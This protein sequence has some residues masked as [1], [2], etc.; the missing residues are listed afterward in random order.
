LIYDWNKGGLIDLKGVVHVELN[1]ETLRDGLQ[2]PSVTDPPIEKK[3]RILHLM[4]QLGIHSANIGLPGAGP[5]AYQDTLALAT[6]IA[7]QKMKIKPNC[8]ARTVRSD[9]TPIIEISQKTGLPIEVATFIGSSPIRQFVEGWDVDM[10]QKLTE[11]AVRYVV[12]N[13]LPSMYVTEDTTRSHPDTIERLYKTAIECGSRRVVIADT[14]GHAIRTGTTNVV[15]FVKDVVESSGEDVKID[16]HGHSDRGF[17]LSCALA[18]IR[19]GVDRVHATALGIG[20][21]SGNTQMDLLLVNLKMMGILN[22][23][24][25]ALH[26]YCTTVAEATEVPVPFNYPIVGNDA[27]RTATGVHAS[28]II[29]AMKIGDNGIADAV[30]SG[31]PAHLVGRQQQIEIGP[32]SGESNV[33]FWLEHHGYEP[34]KELIKKIYE[35]AKHSNKILKD[36]EIRDL[37]FKSTD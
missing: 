30:Y 23:D 21:R 26:E 32:L 12:K 11:D 5:R 14:V 3:I 37:I 36:D 6:E 24:I 4:E 19:A 18:A 8:A 7:H 28:A 13:N 34:K 31:V 17:A 1:D 29:K 35:Y 2:S 33:Q 10:L 22:N 9:I 20:E 16:W 15:R 25:S 27:F